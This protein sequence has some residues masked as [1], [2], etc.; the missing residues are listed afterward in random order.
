MYVCKQEG[1]MRLQAFISMH[2]VSQT[3]LAE[4]VGITRMAVSYKIRGL[5]PWK[6]EEINAVLAFCRQYDP[7]ITYED[8]FG[9]QLPMAAGE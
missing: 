5:R 2:S 6:N 9:E 4:I 3:Q 1:Y 7:S 8:L